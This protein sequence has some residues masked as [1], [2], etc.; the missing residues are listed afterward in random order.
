MHFA[1][2]AADMGA[3][4]DLAKRRN[5]IIIEDAAHG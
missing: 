3:I 2:E 5:L 1:G 4:L